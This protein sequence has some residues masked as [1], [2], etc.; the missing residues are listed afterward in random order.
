MGID[1]Q[2]CKHSAM[3]VLLILVLPALC[4]PDTY[5]SGTSLRLQLH[6]AYALLICLTFRPMLLHLHFDKL[7]AP[8]GVLS[9]AAFLRCFW[10]WQLMAMLH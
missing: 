2:V 5:S 3:L 9:L 7:Q 8:A 6:V 1:L 4:V 10:P